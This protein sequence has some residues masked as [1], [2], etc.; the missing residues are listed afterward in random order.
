MK[1]P[2]T[3][4]KPSLQR[5]AVRH[6]IPRKGPPLGA[7]AD[8]LCRY[9]PEELRTGCDWRTLRWVG[10]GHRVPLE[11]GHRAFTVRYLGQRILISVS[12]GDTSNRVEWI[13]QHLRRPA[14]L[15]GGGQG[16]DRWATLPCYPLIID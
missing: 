7:I 10:P 12:L 13:R 14:A 9:L 1:T 3:R 11:P 4:A 6:R 15:S 16:T 8:S 2:E 5:P